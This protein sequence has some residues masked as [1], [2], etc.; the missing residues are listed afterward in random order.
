MKQT[1]NKF[2]KL[3]ILGIAL[4]GMLAYSLIS[5]S[6]VEAFSSGPPASRTGAPALGTFAAEPTCTACHTTFALNSGPGTLTITGLPSNGAYSPNQEISITVTLTQVDRVRYGFEFTALDDLGQKAGE[7]VVTDATRMRLVDGTGNFAGR[8]YIQHILAGTVPNGTNQSTWT[9]T[10]RAPAQSVGRVTFYVAGNAANG[11]AGNQG[12]YIY[13]INAALQPATTLAAATSVSAASFTPNGS[14]TSES[15]SALFGVNLASGTFNAVGLPLPI[16]LG[17]TRIKVKDNAGTERDA[18]L[19]FVSAGQINYLMPAGTVNGTAAVT[20]IRDNNPI[21]AGN[22]PIETVSPGLFSANISGQ[23]VA[24]AVVLR[25]KAS[26]EQTF[27]PVA[28]LEG[29]AFVPVPIDLGP[30]T[31]Q[32][33]LV[34]FGTGFRAR[35]A[36]SAVSCQIGGVAGDVTFA[37]PTDTFVGL[38]QSNVRLP[39]TLAGRGDVNIVCTVDSKLANTLVVNIR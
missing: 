11:A 2:V 37:G 23:G 27:E 8:Q 39:R 3:A 9:F 13:N 18:G 38:D 25:A 24:A 12:D 4:G 7:L 26:G 34:L 5:G 36:L 33:F 17:G 29:T 14:L 31:D 10:W 16:D 30:E 22:V 21:A 1:S 28:R 6:V 15:I 19:I 20:V 32:V 35:T